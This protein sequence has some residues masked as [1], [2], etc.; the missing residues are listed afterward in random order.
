MMPL[1]IALL[2]ALGGAWGLSAWQE[3]R[4]DGR[5]EAR[6]ERREARRAEGL[7]QLRELREESA[8]LM[9]DVLEGV[10]LGMALE[11]VQALRGPALARDRR[12][13]EEGIEMWIERMPNGAQVAYGFE[14]RLG[15]LLQVQVMSL[16]PSVDAIAPHLT[17]MNETYGPPT[18]VWNCPDTGS[19]GGL[20]TRR[21]TWRHAESAVSD[22]FLIA[23]SGRVSVTLYLTTNERTAASLTRSNCHAATAE[24]LETFP[25]AD[26][27]PLPEAE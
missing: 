23:P 2:V 16:L 6:E 12:D 25:V 17:A 3:S 24:E 20:P 7:E 27:V 8:R 18:G 5:R 15:L 21:F 26:D 19:S 4:A 14:E 11:E 1:G 22:I 13:N 10:A 9:P